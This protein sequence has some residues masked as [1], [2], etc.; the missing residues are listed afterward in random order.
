LAKVPV[1]LV[2]A[3]DLAEEIL[4]QRSSQIVVRRPDW[5]RLVE[6]LRCLEAIVGALAPRYDERSTPVMGA[7]NSSP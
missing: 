2:T 5:L 1:A 7:L 4:L 6:V 3:A